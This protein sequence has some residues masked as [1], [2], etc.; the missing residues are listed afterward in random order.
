MGSPCTS[1]RKCRHLPWE[2][3]LCVDQSGSMADSVI[4]SAIMAGILAGLPAV[5]VRLVVFDISI[6]DLSEH[7]ADPVEGL[8]SVQ[9]GGGTD[10][11]AAVRYC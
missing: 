4:H 3:I 1:H 5:R 7:A 8:M 9:R 6:V 11:G 2:V 10:I